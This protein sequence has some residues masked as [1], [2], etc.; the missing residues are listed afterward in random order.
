MIHQVV[1]SQKEEE[2]VAG[3]QDDEDV[4]E[5]EELWAGEDDTPHRVCLIGIRSFP[6]ITPDRTNKALGHPHVGQE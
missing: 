4:V 1:H 3:L 2:D 6:L 5:V